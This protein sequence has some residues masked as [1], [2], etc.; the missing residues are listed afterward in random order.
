MVAAKELQFP[1]RQIKENSLPWN[2]LQQLLVSLT[3]ILLLPASH[4]TEA[5]FHP[6]VLIHAFLILII[7]LT[8]YMDLH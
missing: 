8:L 7:P 2:H 1:F 3:M 6:R 5:P 4:P